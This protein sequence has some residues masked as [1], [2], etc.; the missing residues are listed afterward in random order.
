MKA[1]NAVVALAHSDDDDTVGDSDGVD[2]AAAG[3]RLTCTRLM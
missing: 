2:A 1:G 3:Q